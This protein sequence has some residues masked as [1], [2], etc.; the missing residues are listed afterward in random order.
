MPAIAAAAVGT[1]IAAGES[2]GDGSHRRNTFEAEVVFATNASLTNKTEDGA[3]LDG[4]KGFGA[5]NGIVLIDEGHKA[6]ARC[7][8]AC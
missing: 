7:S 4:L 1:F 5:R 8:G 3:F 2:L 6:A